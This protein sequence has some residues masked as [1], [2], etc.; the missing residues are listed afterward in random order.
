[1]RERAVVYYGSGIDKNKIKY[2]IYKNM[3]YKDANKALVESKK[4]FEIGINNIT[5]RIINNNL[6]KQEVM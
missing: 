5:Q 4:L 2:E 3:G 1:M 6:K